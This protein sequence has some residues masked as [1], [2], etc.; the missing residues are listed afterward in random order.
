M[1]KR[2]KITVVG[3]GNVGATAAHWAAAKELGDVCLVDIV[4]GLP[5]GKALDL[6]QASPVEGFDC[7]VVGS[8]DY[9]DTADYAL[10]DLFEREDV[11]EAADHVWWRDSV[12]S[13][14][15]KHLALNGMSNQ[16]SY[17]STGAANEDSDYDNVVFTIRGESGDEDLTITPLYDDNGSTSEGT[18]VLLSE[19]EG[20]DE[21]TLPAIGTDFTGFV[22]NFDHNAWDKDVIGFKL[23]T[24]SGD[25]DM[26]YVDSIFFTNMEF[27]PEIVEDTYPTIDPE[28]ILK[29][30]D[31]ERD[32]L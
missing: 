9:A 10:I 8:N 5:Q 16:A 28:D 15:G 20:P 21:E 1:A 30:D 3:A 23:E 29:F 14:I 31:F 24:V 2:K 18:G 19:L 17:E 11:A 25:S 12:G 22:V 7:N 4:E 32:S 27:E 6:M 26:V 13:I